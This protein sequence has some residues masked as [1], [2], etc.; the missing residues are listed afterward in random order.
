L[1]INNNYFCLFL[2]YELFDLE[3][4][5]VNW[6]KIEKMVEIRLIYQQY[7]GELTDKYLINKSFFMI[8]RTF[9]IFGGFSLI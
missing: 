3:G 4:D 2:S 1:K 8:W 6:F 7:D 5:K 9:A